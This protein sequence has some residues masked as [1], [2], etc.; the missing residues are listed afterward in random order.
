MR[1]LRQTPR[2]YAARGSA[3]LAALAAL[4]L[5][6][7]PLAVVGHHHEVTPCSGGDSA[8]TVCLWQAHYAADLTTGG[9]LPPAAGSR[10]APDPSA[11]AAPSAALPGCI[12]RGP[13]SLQA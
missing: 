7:A 3:P 13:P 2:P 10:L 8:C 1:I 6:L 5:L 9:S 12:A 11:P 4:A